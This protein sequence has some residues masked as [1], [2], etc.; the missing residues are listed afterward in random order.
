[1]ILTVDSFYCQLI[2]NTLY[3]YSYTDFTG[4]I[5]FDCQHL[6][7]IKLV[8]DSLKDWCTI[9]PQVTAITR[10]EFEALIMSLRSKALTALK[11]AAIS[12]FTA[13]LFSWAIT[14]Y[15]IRLLTPGDYGLMAIAMIFVALLMVVG[16]LGLGSALIQRQVTDIKIQRQVFALVII[17]YG[18]FYLALFFA[19][20]FIASF[21][22]EPKLTIILQVLSSVFI[23]LIFSVIP[24]S[25]LERELEF[26][27][28]SIAELTGALAGSICTL[29]LAY[30]G[31]GVWSLVVGFLLNYFIMVLGLNLIRPFLHWPDFRFSESKNIFIFGW[32]VT[33]ER[34][35]WY[36]YSQ[37][38][39]FV[40]GKVL[41]KKIT[42]YY[43]VAIHLASLPLQKVSGIFNQVAFPAFSQIQDDLSQTA[44]Y[45]LK[46]FRLM[47]YIA[48]PTFF[49]MS[50]VSQDFVLGVLGEKWTQAIL[51][52]QLLCIIMPLRALENM[53][54][55][56]IRALGKQKVN[57][58]NLGIAGIIM[59]IAFWIGTQWGIVGVSIAWITA[60]PMVFTLVMLRSLHHCGVG[61]LQMLNC[62]LKP[63]L[64][65]AAMYLVIIL[66]R[67]LQI[68]D[69]DPLVN[70]FVF[71]VIGALVYAALCWQFSRDIIDEMR[72][73][74]KSKE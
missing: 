62:I 59:P 32:L 50:A 73:L 15:V 68:V 39:T 21:F 2:F 66:P 26:S 74:L 38:D 46:Y 16:E 67:T 24:Q 9:A 72:G 65:S 18:L 27:H 63:F 20:P 58:V 51:P 70:L 49:G 6:L 12:R 45:L 56:V 1:M 19:S 14:I 23:I 22:N 30:N 25:T 8:G 54:P 34:I 40:I 48:F 31:Y 35:I 5:R 60:Y 17:V 29:T 69:F 53:L 37:A 36:I 47:S 61:F 3:S 52:M 41:G 33:L 55:A 13:Q 11:W 42:G 7:S 4:Q 71:I 28:K 64:F 43:S 10:F 57:I 44:Y